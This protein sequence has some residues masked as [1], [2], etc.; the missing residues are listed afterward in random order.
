M[1]T[2]YDITM[3]NDIGR[4][5]HCEITKGNDVA[6]GIHCDVNNYID[7]TLTWSYFSI[8][9]FPAGVNVIV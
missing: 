9:K 3:G 2:H 4:D 7:Q 1:A 6:R 8:H 5:T